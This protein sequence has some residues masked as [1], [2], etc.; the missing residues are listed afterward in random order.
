VVLVPADLT[1]VESMLPRS[2][3]NSQII[4]L[5]LKRRLTDASSVDKQVI[6]PPLVNAALHYL[7]LHNSLYSEVTENE[8]WVDESLSS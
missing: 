2:V 8:N 5:S 3:A 7:K 1:K 6:K 4:T